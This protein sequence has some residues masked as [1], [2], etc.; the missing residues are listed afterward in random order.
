MDPLEVYRFHP[1]ALSLYYTE[2][3]V[4]FLETLYFGGREME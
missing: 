3:W 2:F 4:L 1:D